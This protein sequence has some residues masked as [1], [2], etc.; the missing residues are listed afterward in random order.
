VATS[1]ID[2]LMPR[3]DERSR[4]ARPVD[5]A[6]ERAIAAVR[7]LRVDELPVTR[8]LMT[9]RGVPNLL[10]GRPL[11]QGRDKRVLDDMLAFGFLLLGEKEREL[12]LGAVG[13]FWRPVSTLR[14]LDGVAG[15]SSFSAPGHARA[16]MDFRAVA[17]NGGCVLTTE[18]RIQAT[19]DRSRRLFRRYWRLVSLGGGMIRNELLAAAARRAERG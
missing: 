4:Y 16:V 7:E 2:E 17:A 13:R 6:P 15:F 18:T 12:A 1:L 10:A 8:A 19:D 3:F 14:P 5:A 9:L 11:L